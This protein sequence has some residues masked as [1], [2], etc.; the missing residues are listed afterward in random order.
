MAATVTI[1]WLCSN[2]LPPFR[3]EYK[4]FFSIIAHL[5][6]LRKK[7]KKQEPPTASDVSLNSAVSIKI[8][9]CAALKCASEYK[10]T[11]FPVIE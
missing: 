6:T 4:F 3:L 8:F 1:S 7:K 5:R 11:V 10:N 2:M 9:S